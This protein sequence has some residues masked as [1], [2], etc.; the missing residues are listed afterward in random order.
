MIS[1]LFSRSPV[2]SAALLLTACSTAPELVGNTS[3]AVL[4]FSPELLQALHAP[5]PVDS[6]WWRSFGDPALNALVEGALAS[7]LD[8]QQAVERVEQARALAR[9]DASALGP[10][11]RLTLDTH[12]RQLAAAEMPGMP[13]AALRND[14]VGIRG[15]VR[16]ELDVFGRLR[17]QADAG[18]LRF[19]AV[20]A[21]AA[22]LQLS[23][24]AETAAA[25]FAL[26]GAREQ[27]RLTRDLYQSW[28]QTL[29]LVQLRVGSGYSAAIDAARIAVELEATGAQLQLLEAT[30]ARETHRLAV[31][32]GN[33]PAQYAAPD[34]VVA[35]PHP[36]QFNIP[37]TSL[38]LRQRPDLR[39]AEARMQAYAL[40]VESLRAEFLPRF[41]LGGVLGYAAGSLSGL[42]SSASASWF[43]SPAVSVPL[44]DRTRLTARLEA[45]TAR[46]REAVLAW[47]QEILL[48]A[49]EV[50]NAMAGVK[51]GQ[52]SLLAQERRRDAA[53]MALTMTQ[54]RYEGGSA[55][56]TELLDVLRTRQLAEMA[57][58]AS[59]TSQRQA[60]VALHRALGSGI[61]HT[62]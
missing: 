8:L 55:D 40:D 10:A 20:A 59:H 24:G 11:G 22:A 56:L 27:L 62:D 45:A 37:A 12:T 18:T 26:E 46:Q 30:V 35:T 61:A 52:T 50:E 2:L 57:L 3:P 32:T 6:G 48:A 34:A 16:W 43:L 9:L 17:D 33:P 21:D 28:Q 54:A 14:L 41:S 5:V 51:L 31:L 49:A 58:V 7:N 38:W 39:A 44:F 29:E 15:D 13:T 25:W 1:A 53:A 19:T 23:L 42:G 4:E 60:I 36:A 47:Q